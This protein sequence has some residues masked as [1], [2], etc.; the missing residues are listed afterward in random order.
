[1]CVFFVVVVVVVVVSS[2]RLLV[3]VMDKN[4]AVVC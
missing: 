3:R 2:M 4:K 1:V